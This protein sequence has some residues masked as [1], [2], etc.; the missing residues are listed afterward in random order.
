MYKRHTLNNGIKVIYE[1]IPYVKSISIGVWV[2]SGSRYENTYNNGVSHFIEHMLFKGTKNRSSKQISEEIEALGG[3]LNAFTSREST[4][5]YVKIL[6]AHYD[7]GIDLLSD[8]IINPT[9]SNEEIEKEKS[10]VLEE[11]SMYEDLPE[12]LVAD[13][14]FDSIWKDNTLSYPILGTEGTV[15]NF[16]RDMVV[17]YYKSRYTPCNTVISVV[18]NFNEKDLLDKINCCFSTWDN[19]TNTDFKE[20]IPTLHK[21]VAVKNKPIEQV[22]VALTLKG[23]ESGSKELYSLLAVNN[24]FGSG[25][26]SKLFQSIREDKGYVYTIYSFPSSYKNSG[27]ITIYFACNPVYLND[28]LELIKSEM[29]EIYINKIPSSEINKLKEQLKGNYILGLEGLSNTMFGIG[30]AELM[31]GKVNTP[32]EILEKIDSITK[33]DIDKTIEYVFSDGII[34]L[35]AV[36]PNIKQEDLEKFI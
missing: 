19:K 12:D 15:S 9:F 26:S 6:D 3:Q 10:V 11:I 24:Y 2:K 29:K 5:Y 8:M 30:K 27:I 28:A 13:I 31:L 21:K 18:G 35:A 25:T 16:T 22:H 14:Q 36:G 33:D 23:Y 1:H 20:D 7:T 32:D 34:S 4:C 17:D